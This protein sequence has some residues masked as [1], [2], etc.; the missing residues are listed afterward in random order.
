MTTTMSRPMLALWFPLAAGPAA[1]TVQGLLG[2]WAGERICSAMSI[3][4]VRGVT[5]LTTL[6][7]L[8]VAMAGIVTALR[9]W[10]RSSPAAHPMHTD[11]RDR[12]E[13]MAL[14]G[15]LVSSAFAIGIVW[16]GLSSVFL[17]ACGRVR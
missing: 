5:A 2:W 1:W 7:A 15:V 11:A 6:A 10:Q 9:T 3:G 17:N 4:A 13:F 16:A 14:G 12:V 8:A